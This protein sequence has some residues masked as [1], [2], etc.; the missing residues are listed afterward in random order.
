[1]MS[2]RTSRT[3]RTLIEVHRGPVALLSD[4]CGPY[5]GLTPANAARTGALP[6]PAFRLVD[7]RSAPLVVSCAVLAAH[8]DKAAKDDPARARASSKTERVLIRAHG[9][10]LIA[11]ASI[12]GPYF[13]LQYEEAR[14]Q[15]IRDVL[16]VPSFRLTK[17]FKAP[18]LVSCVA[19]AAHIDNLAYLAA[20]QHARD[21][22]A[23]PW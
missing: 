11:L 19:L 20:R 3:E 1:M 21:S 16:P 15:S 9:G 2:A 6:F 7:Y 13:G 17:S 5:L 22:D 23:R 10:P 14:K 4:I 12:C 18:L 8:I